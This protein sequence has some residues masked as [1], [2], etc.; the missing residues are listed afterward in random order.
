MEP[1]KTDDDQAPFESTMKSLEAQ[2]T[3]VGAH[4]AIDTKARLIYAQEIK[5]MSDTL[6]ADVAA[7]RITWAAAA[8]QA[9]ETRNL[10][11][12]IMRSRS[13]P[14]GRAFAEKVKLKGL[15]LNQLIALKTVELYG[16]KANFSRLSSVK[17]NAI[18]ARIVTSAG[19]SNTIVNR[20]MGSL[21]YAGRG[22]L[23]VAIA[24][25]LYTIA[26]SSNKMAAFKKELAVNGASVAGGIA[27]GAVA[28]LA[29]GPAAP[30]CVTV[31]AFVG[32][33]LAAFG[34][35]YVW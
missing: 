32:G 11:M 25:S 18:Y 31:G 22:V 23:F 14:V 8:R 33:A 1:N 2:A 3:N 24:L 15:S 4:L 21:T 9:Q 27:G 30:I 28:G 35:S 26:A 19:N 10:I 12:G 20:V 17:Q 5:R 29:C 16:E 6:R 7:R 34:T 13:T